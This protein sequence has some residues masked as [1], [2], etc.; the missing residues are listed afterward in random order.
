VRWF[1][2]RDVVVLLTSVGAIGVVVVGLRL[3]PGISATT[4]ALALLLVVLG[5]ATQ[6]R[7]RIAT[8]VALVATLALNFFFIP[9]IHTFSVAETQNWVALVV[10]LIVAII[11]TNLSAAA[12]ERA[13][14]A[15]RADLAS[16]L[17]AS[18]SHDLRTPL[19]AIKVAMENLSADLPPA[20]RDAQGRAAVTEID[21]LTRLFE[22]ILAM[23]RIDAAAIDVERQWVT[24]ADIVD[25][26]T[27]YARHA[28]EGRPLRVDADDEHEIEL[29]PRLVSVALAHLL[30]NGARYSPPATPIIVTARVD[31]R[32]LRITVS[33]F[34]PGLHAEELE[35]LFE[36][37]YRGRAARQTIG[38]GMGLSIARGLLAAAGGTVAAEDVPGTGA[39]FSIVVPGSIRPSAPA[40]PN[41]APLAGGG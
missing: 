22:D 6:S 36:R 19:T 16:T 23:A 12:Q 3:L 5:A 10:F 9:P 25:A 31:A 24:P 20:D 7:L 11:A 4:A 8:L 35:H 13:R 33:D 17:L 32:E 28:L 40:L 30:E 39:R 1:S 14:E 37:F 15:Q 34:G 41:P 38:T 21:R 29:D 2:R 27:V 18:L 26:A